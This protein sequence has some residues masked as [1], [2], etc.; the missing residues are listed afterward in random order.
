MLRTVSKSKH[1]MGDC[2]CVS[3]VGKSLHH[4]LC[5]HTAVREPLNTPLQGR[6]L[7]DRV[8]DTDGGRKFLQ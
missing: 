1:F 4:G 7:T 6:D 2:H 8:T 3:S 5:D